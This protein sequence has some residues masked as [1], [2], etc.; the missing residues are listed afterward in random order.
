MSNLKFLLV[1]TLVGLLAAVY[2]QVFSFQSIKS[3]ITGSELSTPWHAFQRFQDS[4]P[5]ASNYDPESRDYTP[6]PEYLKRLVDG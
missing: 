4:Q 3:I 6:P 2:P 1:G 5:I